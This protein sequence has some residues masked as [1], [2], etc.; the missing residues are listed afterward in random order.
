M[1]IL[2]LKNFAY[3]Y[4]G[5]T[6]A[7]LKNIT[8]DIRPGECHCL[9]GNTGSGKTTLA[10]ALKDLLPSGAQSGQVWVAPRQDG[11]PGVGL[12]LQNPET[13]LLSPT[14]GA[15]VAFGLENL[16]VD[17]AHMPDRV[18]EALDMVGL[19]R[20][21]ESKT[22]HLSMG[23]KYRLIMAALLVMKPALLVLDEPSAQLDV[24]G[25]APLKATLENLKRAGISFLL[26]EHQPEW[27][28]DA[29]DAYWRLED[30]EL[31]GISEAEVRQSA[32]PG[33]SPAEGA[34]EGAGA[35]IVADRLSAAHAPDMPIWADASF[36]VGQG[37]CV[38][39]CGPNGEGKTTLLRCMAGFL[40][41]AAGKIE[42]L[43]A[44]PDPRVLRGKIGYMLQNPGRQLFENTVFDEVAFSIK[45]LGVRDVAP[46]VS[47]LLAH[48]RIAHLAGHSPHKLSYGQKHLVALASALVSSPRILL[49]DD[50]FAGL[51][52]HC[53]LAVLDLLQA[54]RSHDALTI[55][56]AAHHPHH[57]P[58][59]V[60]AQLR[61]EG[62]RIVV[63]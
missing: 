30:G 32:A 31:R 36:S 57:I 7:T 11:L 33:M 8:L 62:K 13:Q 5:A 26:C 34:H 38:A 44:S 21:L 48:C 27:L 61:I 60:D 43:G 47:D 53:R 58:G 46:R 37:Q 59:G 23:Q 40:K 56:W 29:I 50:P 1:Y 4:S 49:M 35:V 3:T 9:I 45:R 12:V 25:L 18:C 19:E 16:C 41:P 52:R 2:R 15:E 63:H 54:R 42:V 10:L 28:S 20:S 14:V 17:A 22:E 39:V 55:V 6:D 51:D 24:T